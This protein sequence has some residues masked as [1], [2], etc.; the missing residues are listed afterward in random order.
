MNNI[1][2]DKTIAGGM[3]LFKIKRVVDTDASKRFIDE[4][5]RRN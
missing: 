4:F 2:A 1:K 3:E 5:M